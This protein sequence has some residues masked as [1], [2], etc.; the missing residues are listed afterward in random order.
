M[1]GFE[2]I[3]DPVKYVVEHPTTAPLPKLT[4]E[5]V[6]FTRTLASAVTHDNAEAVM[7]YLE[8]L[9]PVYVMFGWQRAVDRDGALY[10][11]DAFK[12]MATKYVTHTLQVEGE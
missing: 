10:S 1:H 8:R 11:T 6:G 4:A 5:A 3:Y 9:G 7:T 12:R 2:N